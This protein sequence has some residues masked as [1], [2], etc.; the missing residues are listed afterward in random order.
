MD[1][2]KKKVILLIL[3][4]FVLAANSAQRPN[5]FGMGLTVTKKQV[6]FKYDFGP[7]R[8]EAG[9][10]PGSAREYSLIPYP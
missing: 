5:P 2:M 4:F 8:V 1:T 6:G 7:G 9:Y 3:S 10:T